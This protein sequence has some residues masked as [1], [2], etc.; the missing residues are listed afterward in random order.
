MVAALVALRN[1]PNGGRACGWLYFDV[2][3]MMGVVAK[4]LTLLLTRC[5]KKKC[6]C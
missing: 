2:E 5:R 1:M 4:V 6:L 3:P